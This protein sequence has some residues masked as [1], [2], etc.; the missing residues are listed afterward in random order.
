[1]KKEAFVITEQVDGAL[2]SS[3]IGVAS[4]GDMAIGLIN[5]YYQEHTLIEFRDVR[6]SGIEFIRTIQVNDYN[7]IPYKVKVTV[8]S[9]NVDEV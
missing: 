7:G 6:D 9:F 5:E 2:D 4:T 1:M 8:L 3:V